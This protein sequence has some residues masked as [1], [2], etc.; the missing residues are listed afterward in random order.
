M[1]ER[2]G[3]ER[4]ENSLHVGLSWKERER[5]REREREREGPS[6]CVFE[7]GI[8]GKV[9]REFRA[10]REEE[11]GWV[12]AKVKKEERGRA[13]RKGEGE[14]ETK[15]CLGKLKLL[16]ILFLLPTCVVPQHARRKLLSGKNVSRM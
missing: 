12:D 10:G 14:R 11:A 4:D 13:G 16:Q 2:E 1:E 3:R 15:D 8:W 5:G 6:T 9:R 7:G